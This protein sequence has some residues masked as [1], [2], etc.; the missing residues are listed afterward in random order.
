MDGDDDKLAE[1]PGESDAKAKKPQAKKGAPPPDKL[2]PLITIDKAETSKDYVSKRPT[3][4]DDNVV[5]SASDV[6]YDP[7]PGGIT[8]MPAT[9]DVRQLASVTPFHGIHV[10]SRQAEQDETL[11]AI[12][13]LQIPLERAANN[14]G[15]K[16]KKKI[17]SASSS[18]FLAAS[19]FTPRTKR[20]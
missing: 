16:E 13:T 12:G 15:T 8:L 7:Q 14:I 1:R 19:E 6:D 9:Q 5:T 11:A 18:V 3:L 17:A 20:T 4:I 10:V 2:A